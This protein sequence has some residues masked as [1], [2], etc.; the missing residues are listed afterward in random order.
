MVIGTYI[1][2]TTL[3]V[4]ELNDPT[5]RYRLPEWIKTQDQYIFC[6]QENHFRPRDTYILKVRGWQKTFHVKGN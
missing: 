3:N 6:I 2:I 4:N 5:K 1:L